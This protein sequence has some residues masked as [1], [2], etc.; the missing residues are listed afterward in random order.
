MS[1]CVF[2]LVFLPAKLHFVL[3]NSSCTG[4]SKNSADSKDYSSCRV[5]LKLFS[6]F[7]EVCFYKASWFNTYQLLQSKFLMKWLLLLE[8]TKRSVQKHCEAVVVINHIQQNGLTWCDV[9]NQCAD[10]TNKLTK[11][12]LQW[13]FHCEPAN[14]ADVTGHHCDCYGERQKERHQ[15]SFILMVM[16][17]NMLIPEH[18]LIVLQQDLGTERLEHSPF[19]YLLFKG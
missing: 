18:T 8:L 11:N 13:G 1:V 17:A 15:K 3:K 2:I 19:F 6:N 9:T 5:I 7:A 10:R 14:T 16:E 4:I 12:G